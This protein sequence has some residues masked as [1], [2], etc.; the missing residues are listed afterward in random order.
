MNTRKSSLKRRFALILLFAITLTATFAISRLA[1][2]VPP[3]TLGAGVT[4]TGFSAGSVTT[5]A[6]FTLNYVGVV[7][8]YVEFDYLTASLPHLYFSPNLGNTI[9]LISAAGFTVTYTT[10]TPTTLTLYTLD[11]GAPVVNGAISL[12]NPMGRYADISS[13]A[14]A[15]V[16]VT[17]APMPPP[18]TWSDPSLVNSTTISG[19]LAVGDFLGL[20]LAPYTLLL[21]DVFGGVVIFAIMMPLYNRT[22]N[23]DYCLVVWVM[24]SAALIVALPANTFR[25]AYVFL[26]IG[27]ATL[28]YKLV[29]PRG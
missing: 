3:I 12:Y 7:D 26:I 13:A 19:Y 1:W 16:I 10:A 29:I 9:I 6:V 25:L 24:L 22:Q 28:L 5:G 15:T 20:V 23:L 18:P 21:G 17:Y 4:F 2:A 27:V 14:G 11:F 8:Q